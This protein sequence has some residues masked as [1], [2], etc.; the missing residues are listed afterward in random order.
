MKLRKLFFGLIAIL[1]IIV[2]VSNES[3]GTNDKNR[4]TET[5]NYKVANFIKVNEIGEGFTACSWTNDQNIILTKIGFTGLYLYDRTKKTV[6]TISNAMSVGYKYQQIDEGNQLLTKYATFNNDEGKQKRK[7]GIKV[8]N[9]KTLDTEFDQLFNQSRIHMPAVSKQKAN[10]LKVGV[11]NKMVDIPVQTLSNAAH[12]KTKTGFWNRYPLVYT[13]EG[14]RLYKDDEVIEIADMY[15]IDAVVSPDGKLMCFNDNGILKIRDENQ[16]E[17]I[18]GEG[19]NASWLPNSAAII[20]HI[21]K[22]DGQQIT[23]SDIYLYDLNSTKIFQLTD[24]EDIL[25][26]YPSVSKDGKQLLFTDIDTGI[27][28]TANLITR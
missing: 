19:I 16:K 8:F 28:Y 21:T 25:E 24:T 9:L 12:K 3:N 14:L 22:D 4:L 18:I 17:Q 5:T 6:K 2:F 26:E 10:T 23:Q 15:G 13:D 20:Y 11:K 7:E 1:T 27:L